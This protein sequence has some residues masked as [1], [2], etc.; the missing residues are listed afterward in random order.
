MKIQ[1]VEKPVPKNNEILVKIH[2]ITVSTGDVETRKFKMPWC[3]WLHARIGFVIMG[4]RQKM[5]V[6]EL[7]GE[8]ESVGKDV[9][10]FKKVTRFLRELVLV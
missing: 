2:A 1:E 4:S 6:R 5:V 10:R 8:I 3:L 7:A 9:K